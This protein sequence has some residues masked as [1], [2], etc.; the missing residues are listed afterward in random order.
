ML[1]V[2]IRFGF[3]VTQHGATGT[4]NIHRVSVRWNHFKGFL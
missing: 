2:E 1:L 3:K 4:H